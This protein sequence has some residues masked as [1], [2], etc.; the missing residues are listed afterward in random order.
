MTE[1]RPR[2]FV[3]SVM[4]NCDDFRDA[5]SQGIQRAGGDPIRAEDFPAASTSPRNA[6]LD[7]VRSANALVLTSG[8]DIGISPW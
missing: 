7:G 8:E 3:S 6:C 2:V 1:P 4:G 5:G